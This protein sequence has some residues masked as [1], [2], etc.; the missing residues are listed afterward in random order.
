MDYSVLQKLI[1]FGLTDVEYSMRTPDY[2]FTGS[3]PTLI[4]KE[5]E[6][7]DQRRLDYV[8]VSK[9]LAG[10][11]KAADIVADSITLKLSDHLPLVVE[12]SFSD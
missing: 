4:E 11:V 3:F 1:D 9:D 10:K 5:G 7:G 8:F 6:D 12:L 2:H